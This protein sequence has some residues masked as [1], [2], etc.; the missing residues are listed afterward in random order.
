V[1][2]A[3]S[4]V[5]RPVPDDPGFAR[6]TAGVTHACGVSKIG[7]GYCWGA[8][9]RGQLGVGSDAF[10]DQP[11]PVVGE[12]SFSVLAAGDNQTCGLSLIGQVFC[13][14]GNEVSA[15]TP[16]LVPNTPTLATLAIGGEF[17]RYHLC[18][19]SGA[20][21][22][23][24]GYNRS[25]ELGRGIVST[26]DPSFFEP[27]ARVLAPAG[28]ELRAVASNAATDPFLE[29]ASHTCAVG[30]DHSVYCWGSNGFGQLGDGTTTQRTT[31]SL[32]VANL[33]FVSVGL[34]SAH[35]CG[36]TTQ[37]QVYCWGNGRYGQLGLGA[38]SG[39]IFS[40]VPLPVFGNR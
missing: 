14:G 33:S 39:T 2:E 24:F 22:I 26:G 38:P 36:L 9:I 27:P 12:I 19:E 31:P 10:G 3:A 21:L 17:G 37:G 5:P 34:G 23:C 4:P 11:K 29:D 1:Q 13:W 7:A 18:G 40:A 20:E 15:F 16:Q 32:V 30:T 25:G 8:N 6:I 35:S 28:V